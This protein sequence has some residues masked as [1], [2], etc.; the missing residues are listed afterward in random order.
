VVEG[1]GQQFAVSDSVAQRSGT[2]QIG[3]KTLG[4]HDPALGCEG[5]KVGP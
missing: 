1:E 5:V 3:P 4:I 2:E